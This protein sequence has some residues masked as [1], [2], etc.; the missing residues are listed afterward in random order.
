MIV[1]HPTPNNING[2]SDE[3]RCVAINEKSKTEVLTK[4]EPSV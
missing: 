1:T 3:K 4:A 2:K